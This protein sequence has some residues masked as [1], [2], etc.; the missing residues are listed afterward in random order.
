MFLKKVCFLKKCVFEKS[1]F[2]KKVCFLKKSG[3]YPKPESIEPYL[4]EGLFLNL[5]MMDS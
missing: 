5:I 3:R 4:L 2:F 1:V